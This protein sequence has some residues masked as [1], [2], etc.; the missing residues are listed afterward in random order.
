[1]L[2]YKAMPMLSSIKTHNNFSLMWWKHVKNLVNY[3][4]LYIIRPMNV[5]IDATEKKFQTIFA[6]KMSQWGIVVLYFS[7][8]FYIINIY[9]DFDLKSWIGNFSTQ[10]HKTTLLITTSENFQ[11]W[12][13]FSL[14]NVD[15]SKF[16][17]IV[18]FFIFLPTM[19]GYAFIINWLS[20]LLFNF[21]LYFYIL[22]MYGVKNILFSA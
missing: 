8:L 5:K 17:K 3:H 10:F 2:Y 1:M 21:G 18:I 13:C 9:T 22:C 14:K 20:L 16:R 12:I 11:V 19:R 4:I 7:A 6:L 15:F